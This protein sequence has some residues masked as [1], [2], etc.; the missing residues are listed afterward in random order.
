[1]VAAPSWKMALGIAVVVVALHLVVP[2]APGLPAVSSWEELRTFTIALWGIQAAVVGATIVGLLF[3]FTSVQASEPTL[4][5]LSE[6]RRRTL[7]SPL[8]GLLVGSLLGMGLTLLMLLPASGNPPLD[9]P[10]VRALPMVDV[11]LF[12]TSMAALSWVLIDAVNFLHPQG[13]RDLALQH[14]REVARVVSKSERYQRA[15][16]EIAKKKL[17]GRN[18][19]FGEYAKEL[20]KSREE[21]IRQQDE[22]RQLYGELEERGLSAIQTDHAAELE[23]VLGALKATLDSYITDRAKERSAHPRSIQRR[24]SEFEYNACPTQ[25]SARFAT[26]M[27]F[28]AGHAETR[29]AEAIT[30]F[31]LEVWRKGV[32]A[33]NHEI[34]SLGLHLASLTYASLVKLGAQQLIAVW[35]NAWCARFHG[36]ENFVTMQ[37]RPAVKPPVSA[38]EVEHYLQAALEIQQT[39]F[40]VAAL[41]LH[42]QD[43]DTS[44]TLLASHGTMANSFY[45]IDEP[46]RGFGEAELAE[47]ARYD[48]ALRESILLWL[49]IAATRFHDG[50]G[51]E[52]LLHFLMRSADN[53][54]WGI[55]DLIATYDRPTANSSA[56]DWFFTFMSDTEPPSVKVQGRSRALSVQ[57]L[58]GWGIALLMAYALAEGD[59]TIPAQVGALGQRRELADAAN[60][61]LTQAN[62]W[63]SVVSEVAVRAVSTAASARRN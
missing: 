21:P 38:N 12:A 14:V 41:A 19:P 57:E 61:M 22:L 7:F 40:L 1:M 37:A 27:D 44:G 16:E 59:T 56:P 63:A 11:A 4:G 3:A 5:A 52:N 50:T 62:E 17:E 35:L 34:S 28:A 54:T 51:N 9:P 31:G 24:G 33:D 42:A 60:A 32:N 8:L 43:F 30:A 53:R 6:L 36:P 23:F 15:R 39:L 20:A 58:K 26:L 48:E 45:P 29:C 46:D 25:V 47:K 55:G 18:L 2:F 10:S 13:V 49:G